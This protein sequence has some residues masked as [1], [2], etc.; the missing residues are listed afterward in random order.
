[1]SLTKVAIFLRKDWKVNR[2]R[3]VIISTFNSSDVSEMILC[4]GFFL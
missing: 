1:M 4:S 2:F 3:D